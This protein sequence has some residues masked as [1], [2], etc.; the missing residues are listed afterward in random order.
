MVVAVGVTVAD[1]PRMTPTCGE[2]MLYCA[3]VTLQFNVT[4]EPDTIDV[5]LAVKLEIVGFGPL[6]TLAEV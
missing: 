2:T 6:G 3:L 5:G 4:G 1:V